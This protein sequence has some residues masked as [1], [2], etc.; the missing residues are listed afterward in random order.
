MVSILENLFQN[1]KINF[2]NVKHAFL[3]SDEAGCYHCNHLIAAVK[4][5]GD[6][7]GITVARYDFS[8]P[9]QGKDVCDRVLC[10]MKAAIRKY[11]AE[12]HDIMN[13]GAMH[14]ALKERPVKG[15]TAAVAILDESSKILEVQKI[16]QFSELHNFRYEESGI[17]VWK[18][19]AVGVG[20]LI[21][22][23]SL[24]IRH[25]GC[26]NISLMEGKGFFTN[27]EIR[28]LHRPRKCQARKDNVEIDDQPSMF[29]CP[30]EGC[31]CTFD[32]FSELELH[33]DVGIHDNRKS[34]SLYDKVRKNWAE[35]FSSIENQK[36]TS[37][38]SSTG[39]TVN[40]T[41]SRLSIGWALNKG[42]TGGVRFSENVRRY[43]TTRFEMGE[44]TGKK[45]NPEEIEHQMRSTPVPR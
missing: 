28:D 4:D 25:Q 43:L 45:A 35:K 19:Y 36:L 31:N 11:C 6:R 2:P 22:W 17:R 37:N 18:A 23:Q 27:T 39:L 44:R 15:T 34:E 24:Y 32:S 33:T 10:P 14:E 1:I 16:K 30:E 40:S 20:K 9:Q 3:R 5:I 21:P 8:E 42:R 38:K 7:V 12:G 29:V 26:T 13:V 41:N